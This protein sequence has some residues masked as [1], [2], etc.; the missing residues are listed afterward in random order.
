MKKI[1]LIT[2][3]VL[4]AIGLGYQ[5]FAHRD[6]SHSPNIARK[7]TFETANSATSS[8]DPSGAIV[9]QAKTS[10]ATQADGPSRADTIALLETALTHPV[11]IEHGGALRDLTLAKDELYI[12]NA[13]GIGRVVSIPS[14]NSASELLD[15]ITKLQKETGSAPELILYP[16]GAV[17]NDSTRRIVTR[18]ILLEADSRHA[19]DSL[20]AASGLSFKSAPA[21]ANGKYIY[22]APS[23][24]EALAFFVKSAESN[25]SPATPLLASLSSKRVMP[26]DQLIQKQWHLKFQGQPGSLADTDMNVESVWKYPSVSK[27]NSSNATSGYIRGNDV[28]IGIVDNGMEWSHPDLLPN[29]I[30]ALQYD[31][32]GKDNDPKPNLWNWDNH[33]TACAGVAAARGNNK[34]GVSGVAPEANLVGMRLTAGANTD[35]DEA[36]A[37]TWH[38]DHIEILS[39]SWGPVDD[40]QTLGRPGPLMLD[41][42]KYAAEFGRGGLGTIIT[43]AGGN[44][45]QNEDNSNYDGYAN[46]IHTIAVAAMDSQ[47]VQAYYSESGANIIITAP[48]DG[49]APAL[50]IMTTDN[51]GPAGYNYGLIGTDIY[52]DPDFRGSGDVTQNFGGTSSATPA[53]SGVI[54][55]MLQRNPNLGWRDVQEILMRTAAQ[56]DAAD[57]DWITG[58]RTDHVTGNATVPFQFNHKY[59]AGLVDA[60]AAVALS[61]NWTNLRQQKSQTVTTN[62][63][64]PI[65]ASATI[66]RTFTVNG[67]NLRAEHATLALTVTDIPKGDLTITLTSPDNTTSILCEPHSDTTSTFTNWKFMTVRNWAESSNG[68]WTLT[69]TNHGTTTGNLTDAKLVVYGTD[70]NGTDSPTAMATGSVTKVFAGADIKLSATTSNLTANGADGGVTFSASLNGNAT[71]L[72]SGTLSSNSTLPVYE[73]TWNTANFTGNYLVTANATSGS[74][75]S[76]VTAPIAIQ[77]DPYPIA[78]WDFD[79]PANSPIPLATAVSSIRKYVANF[80]SGRLTFDG[81]FSSESAPNE[82][83]W[84][85]QEGEISSGEGTSI[86]SAGEMLAHPFTNTGLLLRGGKNNSAEGKF[87]VFAFSMAGQGN[88]TVSYAA[89]AFTDGFTTHEWSYSSNGTDWTDLQTVHPAPGFSTLS[90][91]QTAVLNNSTTA[92]LRLRVSGSGA[93]SGQNLIDNI[94]L[95]ATPIVGAGAEG[96]VGYDSASART[97]SLAASVSAEPT[98]G[99]T[100]S[101]SPG[102]P[103]S[104]STSSPTAGQP[105]QVETVAASDPLDWMISPALPYQML[106]HAEVVDGARFLNA[107]GSL[108]SATK[109]GKV[110]GLANP[111]PQ[112]TH[113][114]LVI[115]ASEPDPALLRLKI[116]DSESKGI[117]VLEEK[118]PFAPDSTIG[119]PATPKRYQVA[120]L[121]TEQVV[122]VSTGWNTFLTAVDPDPATLEGALIDYDATEG[123]RL[124]GPTVN[125]TV[126]QGKW[127]P[128]GLELK[129]QTTYTFLRQAPSDS[130]ILLKGKALPQA[131]PKPPHDKYGIWMNLPAGSIVTMDW[132]DAD[133]DGIDD[134]RQS[135]PGMPEQHHVPL[136]QAPTSTAPAAVQQSSPT[137]PKPPHDKYGIWMDLPAGSIVT[138]DWCDADGDGIDDRRQPAPGMPEQ[139]PLPLHQAPTSTAPAAV[140]QFSPTNQPNASPTSLNDTKKSGLQKKSPKKS[141]KKKKSGGKS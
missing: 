75:A 125:A 100:S 57:P 21:F 94:I 62:A 102:A 131:T 60:A 30:K 39:N 4:L 8:V 71:L 51:K 77:V 35:L 135:A 73:Y 47:G 65:G 115:S 67:T 11:S 23:S 118:L 64:T 99:Q 90:L 86:N 78:A 98:P 101:S 105:A 45:R 1:S 140:Q 114:E 61:G 72:G 127:N 124:V 42:L 88:L 139:K 37:M 34:I 123:D 128:V 22:E 93:A 103:A 108:L 138:M 134:R 133:G 46:S 24:P 18:D 17:R 106:V 130:Q 104:Q 25:S 33:G 136:L 111:I 70:P 59:G 20:V 50:G 91:S 121:E 40:G 28:T 126:I 26:N 89:D 80:G 7:S 10:S 54:A 38:P 2:L 12:R 56:V 79:S 43:F 13:D 14:S 49:S 6:S 84:D 48:S 36:E 82:N 19:A 92:Y 31:W 32:N 29:V 87:L 122:Q 110:L 119:L 58:N 117:L 132:C 5:Q 16:V 95:S 113:Y 97:G 141:G 27:F 116:Y 107:P 66:N 81:S 63:T 52:G 3:L 9:S 129:P 74:G 15:Q 120:Y 109:D 44:G 41:A 85:F 112:T 76:M 68:T 83:H 53:V 69:I 96:S 137:S 55:L